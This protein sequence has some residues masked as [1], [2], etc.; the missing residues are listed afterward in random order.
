MVTQGV[1]HDGITTEATTQVWPG[2]A[3]MRKPGL[4]TQNTHVRIVILYGTLYIL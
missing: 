1:C 4:Y 3:G 2:K